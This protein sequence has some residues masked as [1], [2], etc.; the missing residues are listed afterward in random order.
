M[1]ANPQRSRPFGKLPWLCSAQRAEQE[2][3][4]QKV[5][6][7]ERAQNEWSHG[8]L[9]GQPNAEFGHHCDRSGG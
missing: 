6:G 1:P 3:G 8:R 4:I 2:F 5:E 9:M 7:A